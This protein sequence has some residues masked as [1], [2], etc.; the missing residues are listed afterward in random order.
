[1]LGGREGG[2][3]RKPLGE[4][5]QKEVKKMGA[6]RSFMVSPTTED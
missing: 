2:K 1:M 6:N 4:L 3:T 5:R